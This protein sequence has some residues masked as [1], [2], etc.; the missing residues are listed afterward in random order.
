MTTSHDHSI[1]RV[2][3]VGGG[4]AG[5]MAAAAFARL[6]N[7]GYT[8]VTLIESEE[9]GTVGVGEATIP[10]IITFNQML[11]LDENEFLA[12]TGGTFKLGI[13]FVDWGERG[14]RYF[15][16]FGRYGQDLQGVHFHQLWLREKSRTPALPDIADWA[17]SAVAARGGKFGRAK[18]DARSPIREL[19]YAFHFDASLYAR[20]LRGYAERGGVARIEG[21]IE[22]VGLRPEDGY[23]EAVTLADGRR[24][25]GD[26]FIDCSGFRGLLIEEAL[27]TG[28]ESYARWLPC[29]RAV[30]APCALPDPR[31]PDP[32]TRSTAREAGWQWRIPLQH[33]IG[34]GLVYCSEYLDDDAARAQLLGSLEGALLGDPRQL[35]FTAGRRRQSWNRNVVALGL[36]SGF[37]EP[38]ES[39]SIHLVQAAIQR[40]IALFPDARFDPAERDE[41]NRQMHDLYEDVRDFIILHYKATRRGDTPFWDRV[42]TMDVP[43]SLARKMAL[44]SGK[45]RLFREGYDLFGN[46][47]WVAVCLGQGLVPQGWEPAADALDENLVAQAL[48]QMHQGYAETGARL[49]SHGDFLRAVAPSPL[50]PAITGMTGAS[51]ADDASYDFARTAP[52]AGRAQGVIL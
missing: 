8:Q 26:L 21:R 42:R 24:I 19:F 32:F 43:D 30:A 48:A 40:L 11:G 18:P 41:F 7:N 5:W 1:R 34:N 31:E 29:D 51:N 33:R 13:E 49:P 46:P 39:T 36:S 22:A 25:E 2:V 20:Y 23:V 52:D 14:E 44:W 28:Y 15:H 35:R 50:A 9:I 3:I 6:L 16:P 17:M 38:L 27:G 47:S 45:G 12:A 4:T 37:L 10:P